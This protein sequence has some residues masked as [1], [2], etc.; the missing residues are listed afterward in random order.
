VLQVAIAFIPALA[1][2]AFCLRVAQNRAR[3]RAVTTTAP[4]R[5]SRVALLLLALVL[6]PAFA[7]AALIVWPTPVETLTMRATGIRSYLTNADGEKIDGNRYTQT[8]RVGER[9][10][11]HVRRLPLM[12]P[13]IE[14]CRP[15]A[16]H[17]RD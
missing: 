12:G 14:S 3:Q 16:P 15:L 9:A 1:A 13:V 11:C 6:W 4:Q 8:L 7:L 10:R 5:L 2:S 17:G